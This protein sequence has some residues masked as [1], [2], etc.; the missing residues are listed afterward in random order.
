V[1]ARVTWWRKERK[2]Y[3]GWRR[4]PSTRLLVEDSLADALPSIRGDRIQLQQ[5]LLNVAVNARDRD[6]DRGPVPVE[7]AISSADDVAAWTV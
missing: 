3:I 7:T 2:R 5:V 6:A 4:N 1:C